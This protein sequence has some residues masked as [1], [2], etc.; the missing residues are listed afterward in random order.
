MNLARDLT[1]NRD[2]HGEIAGRE[3]DILDVLGIAWRKACGATGSVKMRCPFPDHEDRDPSWRWDTSKKKWHCTCGNGSAFDAVMRMGKANNFL[4]SVT[5]VRTAL[6]LDGLS[7]PG[8][9]IDLEKVKAEAREQAKERERLDAEEKER[10]RRWVNT[11]WHQGE[12][13]EGTVVEGYLTDT[14]RLQNPPLDA[15]R[16]LPA[17]LAGQPYPAMMAAFGLPVEY[18]PGKLRLDEASGIHLTFLD[19][20]KKAPALKPKMMHGTCKGLPIVLAP[21]NDGLAICIAE[22]IETALSIHAVTG[23]GAWAAGSAGFM[24][25]LADVVPDIIE[26][27]T[28][29]CEE[30]KAGQDNAREL[31][32]RLK[33]RGFEVRLAGVVTWAL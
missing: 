18:E 29:W 7:A 27:V 16:Y 31:H 21:P 12:P 10:K 11:R 25:D 1:R 30:G 13:A 22:G 19:G 26:S 24:P 28:I 32:E 2:A 4:S 9:V 17:G 3:T 15:L 33:A 8:A 23:I 20:I 14:R 5:W 6:K